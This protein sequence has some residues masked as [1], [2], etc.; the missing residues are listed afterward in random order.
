MRIV[1]DKLL[2]DVVKFL[3][4]KYIL[5]QKPIIAGGS[6]LSLYRHII[7]NKKH[8]DLP[9]EFGDVDCWFLKENPIHDSFEFDFLFENIECTPENREIF[10]R[11]VQQYGYTQTLF[12]SSRWANTFCFEP[13]FDYVSYFEQYRTIEYQIVKTKPESI[14]QLLSSFDINIV[15]IAWHNDNVYI[16][17][18]ADKALAEDGE[19]EIRNEI[20]SGGSV[21]QK[22]YS[23]NRAFKHS[24]RAGKGFSK[25]TTDDVFNIFLEYTN[26]DNRESFGLEVVN[27]K[28]NLPITMIDP[29]T[30]KYSAL[31]ISEDVKKVVS[32]IDYLDYDL[33]LEVMERECLNTSSALVKDILSNYELDDKIDLEFVRTIYLSFVQN[34]R[35]LINMKHFDKMK[36]LYFVNNK[37]PYIQSLTKIT[38]DVENQNHFEDLHI[39]F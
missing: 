29:K 22:I 20:I 36:L 13:D 24:S 28:Q 6:I 10:K 11:K 27:E 35:Y 3:L 34:F 15:S 32:D 5:E 25:Q 9:V 2:N 8:K 39:P 31:T 26:L 37:E 17:E 19:I 18:R 33:N 21:L 23:V 4:P 38:V 1:K 7:L 30:N 12:K 16:S 14:E